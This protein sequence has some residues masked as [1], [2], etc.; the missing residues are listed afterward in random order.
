MVV[1]N[2]FLVS[3]FKISGLVERTFG[4]HSVE[5]IHMRLQREEGGRK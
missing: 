2:D 1:E 3:G 5:D 4:K